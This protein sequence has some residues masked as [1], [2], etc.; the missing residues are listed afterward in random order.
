MEK[1]CT[2]GTAAAGQKS[3]CHI[4]LKCLL[5]EIFDSEVHCGWLKNEKVKRQMH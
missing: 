2:G 4:A 1:K 5:N 3:S